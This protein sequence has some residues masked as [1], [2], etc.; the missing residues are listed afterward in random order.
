MNEFE[1][2]RDLQC[3][4]GCDEIDYRTI[5]M[6]RTGCACSRKSCWLDKLG[7]VSPIDGCLVGC[8]FPDKAISNHFSI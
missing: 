4:R 2:A 8:F 3:Q 6:Q 5:E 1:G 7:S